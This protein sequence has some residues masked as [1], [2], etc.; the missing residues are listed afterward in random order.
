M[1]SALTMSTGPGA[2]RNMQQSRA[3][4]VSTLRSPLSNLKV[5]ISQRKRSEMYCTATPH[6]WTHSGWLEMELQPE[7]YENGGAV[8]V[9]LVPCRCT[10]RAGPRSST[11]PRRS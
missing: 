2:A 11:S 8:N 1:L 4:A 9:P 6:T 10:S 7:R 5:F 3:Q